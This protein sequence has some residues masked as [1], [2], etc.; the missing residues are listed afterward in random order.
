MDIIAFKFL[1]EVYGL[2][3][4][5][6]ASIVSIRS[7]LITDLN[8]TG[9]KLN[10]CMPFS[11][12]KSTRLGHHVWSRNISGNLA[13][14][15][16]RYLNIKGLIMD[17]FTRNKLYF[18]NFMTEKMSAEAWGQ[19]LRSLN[20]RRGN[21]DEYMLQPLTFYFIVCRHYTDRNSY[22]GITSQCLS[23]LERCHTL[24]ATLKVVT[25]RRFY[26]VY[27]PWRTN[28]KYARASRA[29]NTIYYK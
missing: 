16:C 12:P 2:Y 25:S 13:S 17:W 10:T 1:R 18:A 26:Q 6:E 21:S 5:F 14:V 24:C 28:Q 23:C 9:N 11:I 29:T 15:L 8:S 7:W 20:D 3:K 4:L 19:L 22:C 27:T